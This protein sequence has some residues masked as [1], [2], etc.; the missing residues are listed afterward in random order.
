MS[1]MDRYNG[2]QVRDRSRGSREREGGAMVYDMSY[3]RLN[4]D[5]EGAGRGRGRSPGRPHSSAFLR[6]LSTTVHALFD[7]LLCHIQRLLQGSRN[8][9]LIAVP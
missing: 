3:G 4:N 1:F 5:R 9:L 7:A 2:D 8:D 6:V